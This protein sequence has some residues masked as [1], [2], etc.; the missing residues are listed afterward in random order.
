[1]QWSQV[2]PLLESL[3]MDR[4]RFPEIYELAARCTLSHR[5]KLSCPRAPASA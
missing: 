1:M 2:G 5:L 3:E 4:L